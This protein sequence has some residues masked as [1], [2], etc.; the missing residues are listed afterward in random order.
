MNEKPLLAKA[1]RIE[2][3][4]VRLN[5]APPCNSLDEAFELVCVTLNSVE[6]EFTDIPYNQ[7]TSETDG[8]LYPPLQENLRGVK[9]HPNVKRH[10]HRFHVT[11]F[12]RKRLDRNPGFKKR[13]H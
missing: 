9:D 7:E 6:D 3:F 4:L 11:Y 13:S 5:A 12:W 2:V 8:R 1:A 10:R